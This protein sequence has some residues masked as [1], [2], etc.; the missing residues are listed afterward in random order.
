[1]DRLFS[2]DIFR[3]CVVNDNSTNLAFTTNR[4][5]FMRVVTKKQIFRW[6]SCMDQAGQGQDRK[7]TRLRW[8]VSI[9]PVMTVEMN[10]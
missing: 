4:N 8:L 5:S 3:L 6:D 10:D 9:T 7:P 2:N 1:M